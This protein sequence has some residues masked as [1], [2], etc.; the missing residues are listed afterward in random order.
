[1]APR[2]CAC[3]DVLIARRGLRGAHSCLWSGRTRAA[4][5][6]VNRM[7]LVGDTVPRQLNDQVK[8][9]SLLT[10][11]WL[12]AACPTSEH[13]GLALLASDADARD[14]INLFRFSGGCGVVRVQ[15]YG[16]MGGGR[17]GSTHHGRP[18]VPPTY[19]NGI[20]SPNPHRAQSGQS[21]SPT[22]NPGGLETCSSF[23]GQAI[24]S[25]A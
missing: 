21:G 6:A 11:K 13:V 23:C 20:S 10:L 14:N 15:H 12:T 17:A 5:L 24:Y 9:R 3:F 1:M 19:S 22:S 2:T 25:G 18:I 8:V 7:W 4:R 16:Q